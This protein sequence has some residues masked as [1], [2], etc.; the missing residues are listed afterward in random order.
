[1]VKVVGLIINLPLLCVPV[2]VLIR[3]P[4]LV[5]GGDTLPLFDSSND[6]DVILPLYTAAPP[7][8][9]KPKHR[10]ASSPKANRAPHDDEEGRQ[11]GPSRLGCYINA[12]LEDAPRQ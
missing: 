1:M 10:N 5:C 3:L 12:L 9:L 11:N 7:L 2:F 8:P 4:L 6:I